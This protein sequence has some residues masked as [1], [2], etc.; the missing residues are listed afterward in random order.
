M[1]DKIFINLILIADVVEGIYKLNMAFVANLFNNH[2][3][4]DSSN[5]DLE[6]YANV[7]ESRE[8]KTYRNWMNSL[9]VSPYVNNL[10][11]DLGLFFFFDL[12]CL[13]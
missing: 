3:G 1:A 10:S 7:E 11:S 2:P 12:L 5:I 6:D 9:G 8:E 4:M 13:L